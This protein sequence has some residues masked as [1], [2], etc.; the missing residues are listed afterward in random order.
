MNVFQS[1]LDHAELHVKDTLEARVSSLFKQKSCTLAII[2]TVTHGN[3]SHQF[4]LLPHSHEFLLGSICCAKPSTYLPFGGIGQ[5]TP[6]DDKSS[7]TQRLLQGLQTLIQAN[8]YVSVIGDSL[9]QQQSEYHF[10]LGF[11]FG[12]EEKCK[13]LKLS[14]TPNAMYPYLYQGVLAF[15]AQYLTYFN[16]S[17]LTYPFNITKGEKL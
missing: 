4:S 9:R 15:L 6:K 3:L 2:D 17:Q 8:F 13:H 10:Q 11:S 12:S 16:P 1:E 5:K 14:G 7:L